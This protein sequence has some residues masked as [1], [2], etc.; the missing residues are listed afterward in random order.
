MVITLRQCSGGDDEIVR[1]D[2]R[3]IAVSQSEQVWV[4]FET[5]TGSLD[6]LEFQVRGGEEFG[7]RLR[8]EKNVSAK[9]IFWMFAGGSIRRSRECQK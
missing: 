2:R 9:A 4:C 1:T 6:V 5:V 3:S 8:Q 7:K